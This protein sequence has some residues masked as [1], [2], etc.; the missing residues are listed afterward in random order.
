[1]EPQCCSQAQEELYCAPGKLGFSF[2]YVPRMKY[3]G[4]LFFRNSPFKGLAA[5]GCKRQN[6]G[7][8][9]ILLFLCI[10][11]I[12]VP[13]SAEVGGISE[14]T[15]ACDWWSFGAL[16]YE[17]LSGMVSSLESGTTKYWE[18]KKANGERSWW[19]QKPQN[20]NALHC[21]TGFFIFLSKLT[22]DILPVICHGGLRALF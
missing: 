4:P 11:V 19:L 7:L 22:N 1:M 10:L 6:K 3:S 18:T 20:A 9:G 13:F 12:L 21:R 16:L 17:L 14:L 8:V 5:L 2:A 15:E